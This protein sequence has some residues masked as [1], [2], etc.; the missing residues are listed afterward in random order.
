MTEVQDQFK[1]AIANALRNSMEHRSVSVPFAVIVKK[2]KRGLQETYYVSV[3]YGQHWFLS[4]KVHR[5]ISSVGISD[6]FVRFP[7]ALLKNEQISH[8]VQ[9]ALNEIMQLTEEEDWG[10]SILKT[11]PN[12]AYLFYKNQRLVLLEENAVRLWGKKVEWLEGSV[13]L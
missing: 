3:E 9:V 6:V 11:N 7:E 4:A 8:L 2:I 12:E 1:K 10:V 13:D 5:S